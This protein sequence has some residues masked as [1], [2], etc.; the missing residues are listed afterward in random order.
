MMLC[1]YVANIIYRK[2]LTCEKIISRIFLNFCPHFMYGNS[3]KTGVLSLKTVKNSIA[4]N[5]VE[6]ILLIISERWN[7]CI[8]KGFMCQFV[9]KSLP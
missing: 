3:V 6:L 7:V 8:E 2:Y 5:P 9:L 1:M 4:S